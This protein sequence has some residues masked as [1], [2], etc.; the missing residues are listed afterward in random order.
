MSAVMDLRKRRREA[1]KER[2]GVDLGFMSFFV[3]ATIGALKAFPNV[4]AETR[5]AMRWCSSTITISASPSA[6][7]KGWWCR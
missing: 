3:K 5:R 1:F 2:F 6:P 7:K 4:N